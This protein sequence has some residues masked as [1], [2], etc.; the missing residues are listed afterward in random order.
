LLRSAKLAASSNRVRVLEVIG[1][2]GFPLSAGDIFR[3][4]ARSSAI[5]RVTVYRILDF[6]SMPG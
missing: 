3:I 4:M 5:N 2:N 6:W 1:N